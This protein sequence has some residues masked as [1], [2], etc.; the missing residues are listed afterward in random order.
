MVKRSVTSSITYGR[1]YI[2]HRSFRKDHISNSGT[3]KKE[4]ELFLD[5]D[6]LCAKVS[7]FSI[8]KSR[9]TNSGISVEEFFGHRLTNGTNLTRSWFK[10]PST[11]V[12]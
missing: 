10:S 3:G 7:Q 1:V 8:T 12:I 11:I 4:S 6:V 2:E 5:A 9:F